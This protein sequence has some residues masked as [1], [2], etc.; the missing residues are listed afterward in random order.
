MPETKQHLLD[1]LHE[2]CLSKQPAQKHEQQDSG[3]NRQNE[4][5]PFP[6][7]EAGELVAEVVKAEQGHQ[8]FRLCN[9]GHHKQQTQQQHVNNPF[10]DDGAKV[11][12]EGYLLV[13][14]QICASEQFSQTWNRH[15]GDVAYHHR[16]VGVRT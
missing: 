4:D 16:V 5:N 3:C 8:F 15:V 6:E 13:G 12:L 1:L 7:A 2:F 14:L 9:D 11:F 10:S